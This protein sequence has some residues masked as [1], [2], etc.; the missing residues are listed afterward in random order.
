M[1][2]LAR[3]LPVAVL[4]AGLPAWAGPGAGPKGK[5]T[6]AIPESTLKFDLVHLEGGT[7]GAR[8]IPPFSIGAHEV[9][10]QL[11]DYFFEGS[12]LKDIDTITRPTKAKSFL[13]QAGLPPEFMEAPRPVTNLRWHSAVSYCEWLSRKTGGY[14]RLPTEAEWEFAARAGE[15]GKVPG[16]FGDLVWHEGNSKEETH[17]GG[18]KKPNAWGLSDMLGNVWEYCLEPDKPPTFGPVLRGGCWNSKPADMTFAARSIVPRAWFDDDPNRPRSTWWLQSNFSQGFR[19]V[20]VAGRG[21][22]QDRAGYC[23]K[24]KVTI[25]DFTEKTIKI[26]GAHTFWTQVKGKI[27]NTGDRALTEVEVMLWSLNEDGKIHLIDIRGA[28]K[29]GRVTWSKVWPVM[30]AGAPGAAAPLKPGEERAFQVDL[31]YS[32]DEPPD[33]DPE[34]FG[35]RVVN[36]RFAGR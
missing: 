23:P 16:T 32:F 14:Y 1:M 35:G 5:E 9:T 17:P 19:V 7:L 27:R 4:L 3:L 18:G 29:P 36:V 24:V 31:P 13:G 28:D 26:E 33:V 25:E 34:A 20:R 6:V 12:D 30:A 2:H 15:S 11:F 8:K 21:S 22:A 10:W